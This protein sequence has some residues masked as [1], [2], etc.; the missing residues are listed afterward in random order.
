MG[1][2][3]AYFQRIQL[4]LKP[5]IGWFNILADMQFISLNPVK[6][7]FSNPRSHLTSKNTVCTK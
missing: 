4:A 5:K 6:S 2:K 3:K 1:K 7:Y